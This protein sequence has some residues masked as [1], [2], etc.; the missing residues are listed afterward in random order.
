VES[1]R[2]LLADSAASIFRNAV[3]PQE[4][5]FVTFAKRDVTY[6]VK[7]FDSRFAWL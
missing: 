5:L 2:L 6:M 3:H 1:K 7:C 4:L